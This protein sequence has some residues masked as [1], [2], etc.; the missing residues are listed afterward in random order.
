VNEPELADIGL[1]V[2]DPV[3]ELRTSSRI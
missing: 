2:A 1:R 3:R